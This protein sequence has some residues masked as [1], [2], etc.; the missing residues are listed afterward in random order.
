MT[1]A[2]LIPTPDGRRF[3]KKNQLPQIVLKVE[4][5]NCKK[6][7][8]RNCKKVE[9][10]N[11]KK[12]E[13]RN[14]KKVESRK[15]KKVKARNCKKVEA[16]NCKKTVSL[17][18]NLCAFG[19]DPKEF[20]QKVQNAISTGATVIPEAPCCLGPQVLVNGNQINFI[21]EVLAE[22][23]GL[24]KEYINGTELGT[25]SK[26]EPRVDRAIG[27]DRGVPH[28][29]RSLFHRGPRLCFHLLLSLFVLP[30]SPLIPLHHLY[31]FPTMFK[32]PFKVKTNT[33]IKNSEKRKLLSN[34]GE[35]A[36]E[37]FGKAQFSVAIV[38]LASEKSIAIYLC[39]KQPLFFEISH[40]ELYPS[41]YLSWIVSSA[42]P[43]LLI[44]E[45]TFSF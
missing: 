26:K 43:T 40:G 8:T 31:F 21:V 4:T 10:R 44:N 45:A 33:N 36:N 37:L 5:R 38:T 39:E 18:N 25:K 28:V 9:A 27:G 30:Y 23:Y 16:I 7:E 29:A 22:N 35:N 34:I 20:A 11:C 12:V 41:V 6:V 17:V 2:F 14:C 13:A 19:I 24:Q 1:K 42:F 32:H 3:L 15:Y